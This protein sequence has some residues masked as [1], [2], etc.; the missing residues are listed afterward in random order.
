MAPSRHKSLFAA[1]NRPLAILSSAS[2]TTV[3][4]SSCVFSVDVEDW[5]HIMDLPNGPRLAE[6]DGLPSHVERNFRVL[7]ELLA[8]HGVRA[9]FFFL[10]WVAERHPQLVRTAATNGHEVASHGYGHGLVYELSSPSSSRTSPGRRSF[11]KTPR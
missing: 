11:S 6:W 10:G 7:I 2:T 1:S 8:E 9:T 5:F 4:A 3:R